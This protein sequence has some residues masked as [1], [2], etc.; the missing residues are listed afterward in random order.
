MDRARFNKIRDI[1]DD[2]WSS[3][4]GSEEALDVNEHLSDDARE[5]LQRAIEHDT[6]AYN[7]LWNELWSP[8][9]ALA[10][11]HER[12]AA[13]A[14]GVCPRCG[15]VVIQSSG[16]D[17]G[18]CWECVTPRCYKITEDEIRRGMGE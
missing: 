9:A 1:V 15:G 8:I 17:M 12:L 16:G 4:V 5:L 6:E 14:L 10:L 2:L 11:A 3:I 18:G 13:V 7:A